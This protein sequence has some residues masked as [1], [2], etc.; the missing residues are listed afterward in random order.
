VHDDVLTSKLME[1]ISANV[2]SAQRTVQDD[3]EKERMEKAKEQDTEQNKE[4]EQ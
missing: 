4:K 3:E 1:N 2:D